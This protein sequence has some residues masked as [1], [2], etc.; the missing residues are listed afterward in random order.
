M[1]KKILI[2]CILVLTLLL[3]MPSIPA[4]QQNCVEEGIKQDIREKL[5]TITPDDV[6]YPILYSLL[7]SWFNFRIEQYTITGTLMF[8]Y[9]DEGQMYLAAIFALRLFFIMVPLVYNTNFWNDVSE[10]LGWNWDIPL[11][12]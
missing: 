8:Q 7:L 11:L 4:I 6:K 10:L 5:D 1:R 2:G 12:Y 9:V 3:L